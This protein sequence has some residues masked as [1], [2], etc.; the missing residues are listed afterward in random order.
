[1]YHHGPTFLNLLSWPSESEREEF[2]TNAH[3][4]ALHRFMVTVGTMQIVHLEPM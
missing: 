3:Y 2:Y 1:F 4:Q